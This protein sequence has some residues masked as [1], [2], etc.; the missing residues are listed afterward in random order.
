MVRAGRLVVAEGSCSEVGESSSMQQS[1]RWWETGL[2]C[3]V[4]SDL[5]EISYVNHHG[6]SKVGPLL[7]DAGGCRPFRTQ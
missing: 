4:G 7:G 5:G 6:R 2:R 3:E 1:A